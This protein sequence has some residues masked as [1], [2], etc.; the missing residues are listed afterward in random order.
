MS[1]SKTST[2]SSKKSSTTTKNKL[3]RAKTL[4]RIAATRYRYR[5]SDTIQKRKTSA[6]IKAY[7]ELLHEARRQQQAAMEGMDKW[8]AQLS[9]QGTQQY[10]EFF[11]LIRQ[12]E[13]LRQRTSTDLSKLEKT[14]TDVQQ[15]NANT[16]TVDANLLQSMDKKLDVIMA[17]SVTATIPNEPVPDSVPDVTLEPVPSTSSASHETTRSSS[18][19]SHRSAVLQSCTDPQ[20]S[21]IKIRLRIAESSST[22]PVPEPL[23]SP[24]FTPSKPPSGQN[25]H[26]N[27]ITKQL[28]TS[29]AESTEHFTL[30]YQLAFAIRR[31][32]T[33]LRSM[34]ELSQHR[35]A[36]Q[37]QLNRTPYQNGIIH[38]SRG[39]LP[40]LIVSSS[41]LS[42]WLENHNIWHT[43]T[44]RAVF[45]IKEPELMPD[46][47]M[48]LNHS[49]LLSNLWH[50]L[51]TTPRGI[52]PS[53]RSSCLGF[54]NQNVRMCDCPGIETRPARHFFNQWMKV[55]NLIP[56]DVPYS[57]IKF[58]VIWYIFFAYHAAFRKLECPGITDYSATAISTASLCKCLPI[59][60]VN[61]QTINELMYSAR[62]TFGRDATPLVRK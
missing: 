28:R 47:T 41:D 54:L 23:P 52:P 35:H 36:R 21:P 16:T 24:S 12:L 25:Q 48:V 32:W 6:L 13:V 58:S 11:E 31:E 20:V 51:H 50:V 3:D 56:F 33:E 5:A 17:T 9:K 42:R 53:V 26:E 19:A 10:G 37:I 7:E 8:L 38:T 18:A 61:W 39:Y 14:I 45:G 1:D 27:W 55:R 46:V 30:C 4:R 62:A 49:N 15:C 57:P 22:W 44:Y 43:L 34:M 60:P 59:L 29:V 40:S 2:K